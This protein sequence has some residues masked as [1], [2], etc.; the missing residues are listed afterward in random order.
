MARAKNARLL[1]NT[2]RPVAALGGATERRSPRGRG[3]FPRRFNRVPRPGGRA[4]ALIGSRCRSRAARESPIVTP[5]LKPCLRKTSKARMTA[6][7]F[8]PIIGLEAED[9]GLAGGSIKGRG[10][11]R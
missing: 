10:H 11:L 4:A 5:A 9:V 8:C 1:E 6:L 3:N 7:S 2:Q